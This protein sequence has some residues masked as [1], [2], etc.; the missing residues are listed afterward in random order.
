MKPGLRFSVPPFARTLAIVCLMLTPSGCGSGLNAV[1]VSGKILI[2]GKPLT[3]GDATVVFRPDA[4]KGNNIEIDFTGKA[5]KD[6]NYTLYYQK[7]KHGAVPGWYKVGV[8]ATE[9]LVAMT[10]PPSDTRRVRMIGMPIR[11]TLVLQKYNV[12]ATSGIEIEVVENPAPAAYDL[13]LKGTP[14]K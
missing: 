12:P 2:D 7:G 9:P 11:K 13:N 6:G 14:G 1:P 8:V 5:D 4:S 10:G 3:E